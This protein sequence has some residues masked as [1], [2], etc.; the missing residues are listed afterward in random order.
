MAL[1]GHVLTRVYGQVFGSPP[2]QNASGA[3]AFS[4][5]KLYPVAPNS[6]LPTGDMTIWPLPNG[7]QVGRGGVN[8]YVYSVLEFAPAGLNQPTVKL[9]TDKSAT[10][11]AS[12]AT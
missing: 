4:S 6:Y 9:V 10:T 8:Y 1:T 3:T 2:F 5:D 7:Y 12:D 11:L